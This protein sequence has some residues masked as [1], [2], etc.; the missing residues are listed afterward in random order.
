MRTVMRFGGVILGVVVGGTIGGLIGWALG[1]FGG[2]SDP[3][4]V[5]FVSLVIGA[6]TGLAIATAMILRSAKG[7]G[8]G[9]SLLVGAVSG[10]VAAAVFIVFVAWHRRP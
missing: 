3:E 10:I 1:D 6:A 8:W 9:F 5:W 7:L 4:N 2:R